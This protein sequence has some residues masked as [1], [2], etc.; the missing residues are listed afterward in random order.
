MSASGEGRWGGVPPASR[1]ASRWRRSSYVE[2]AAWSA[3]RVSARSAASR[4]TRLGAVAF[5]AEFLTSQDS[6]LPFLPGRMDLARLAELRGVWGVSLHSLVHRCR[7][8]GLISDA[9]AS[10]TYQ[11]L[12]ALDGQPGFTAESVSNFP[13]ERPLLLR[14]AF[15]LAAKEAGLSVSQLAH[16]LAWTSG[17]VQDLLGVQEQR[18]VLRLVQ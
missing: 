17:R 7:E 16:E 15:E 11:R 8:L 4:W 14:Q 5:A 18:P 12:R 2:L 13:G 10:R 9:T 3:Y 6:I 1:M